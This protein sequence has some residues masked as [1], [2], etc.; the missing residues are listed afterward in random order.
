ML[1]ALLVLLS[2]CSAA[3]YIGYPLVYNTDSNKEA[4][5]S[6]L[7]ILLSSNGL[8]TF[9]DSVQLTA[10]NS[11]NVLAKWEGVIAKVNEALNMTIEPAF[12]FDATCSIGG[13]VSMCWSAC[14]CCIQLLLCFF[15]DCSRLNVFSNVFTAAAADIGTLIRGFNED[16]VGQQFQPIGWKYH[17]GTFDGDNNVITDPSD[18]DTQ[19]GRIFTRFQGSGETILYAY[20]EGDDGTDCELC[21]IRK[22]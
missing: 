13:S 2:L 4:L 10:T 9:P 11:L 5:L 12:L 17:N 22:C 1:C 8:P 20:A 15:L 14:E 21:F 6:S 16:V 19:C 18:V 7:N 3:P